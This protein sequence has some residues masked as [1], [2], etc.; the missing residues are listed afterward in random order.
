MSDIQPSTNLALW[1]ELAIMMMQS[2][3][4]RPGRGPTAHLTS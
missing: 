1:L 3:E 2:G 4:D